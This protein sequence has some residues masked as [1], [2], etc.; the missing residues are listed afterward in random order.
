M[1]DTST[2]APA[3]PLTLGD[4]QVEGILGEGGSGT[5][6]AATFRES[7]I[8]LKVLRADLALS[9]RERKRFLE[10][11]GNMQRVRHV[12]LITMLGAGLLADG[13]PYICMPRLAGETLA[14]RLARGRLPLESTLSIFDLMAKAVATLHMAGLVHR[15]IKPE[16]VFLEAPADPSRPPHPVLLDFGIA[17]DLTQGQSTTTADGQFRGTPAYMAPERFFGSAANVRSDV[18]ELAVT[19]Y[20]MLVGRRPWADT[21]DA[22]GRLSPIHPRDFGVDLPADLVTVVLRALSTRPEVRPESALAF[23]DAV[24]DGAAREATVGS[25]A[26]SILT[27]APA[28]NR[29]TSAV[30][31]A[32]P[33]VDRKPGGWRTAGAICLAAGL[34]AVVILQMPDRPSS[35]TVPATEA[36]TRS[37]VSIVVPPAPS[38]LNADDERAPPLSSTSPVVGWKS[39]AGP[40]FAATVR[41][42]TSVTPMTLV[43]PSA[44]ATS[45]RY[46]L[47]RK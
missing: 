43:A 16:N 36:T 15:D 17:R 13:R 2:Y 44:S 38:E 25:T 45:N 35:A 30:N 40:R 3:E 42:S 6:Y 12:G 10:E 4:F 22:A 31:L 20:M 19:L 24:R 29:A 32:A 5:V 21:G 18:Y 41:P 39:A 27:A 14:S 37:A 7:G 11:A 33:R 9:D 47:D 23:A 28:P 46:Y 26:T 34:T 8:A 1:P